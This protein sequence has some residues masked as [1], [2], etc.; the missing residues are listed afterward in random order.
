LKFDDYVGGVTSYAK[1]AKIG[2]TELA[3]QR[4]ELVKYHVHCVKLMLIV[5]VAFL[6]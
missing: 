3:C 5:V 4:G 2:T 6:T 1:T